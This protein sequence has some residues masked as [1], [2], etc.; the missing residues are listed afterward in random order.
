MKFIDKKK[1]SITSKSLLESDKDSI[2]VNINEQI[3]VESVFETLIDQSNGNEIQLVAIINH[4]L[5][6]HFILKNLYREQ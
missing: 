5:V 4:F 2:V 1:Y 6:N 3:T